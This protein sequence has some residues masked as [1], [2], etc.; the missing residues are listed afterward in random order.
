MLW[1]SSLLVAL[2]YQPTWLH[3]KIHSLRTNGWT[4]FREAF[5]L[6]PESNFLVHFH[7]FNRIHAESVYFRGIGD[8]VFRSAAC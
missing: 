2:P 1:F 6:V 3:T 5:F 4:R 7:I 8:S